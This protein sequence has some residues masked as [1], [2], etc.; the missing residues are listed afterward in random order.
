MDRDTGKA[1]DTLEKGAESLGHAR[2]Y[3]A[4]TKRMKLCGCFAACCP[5]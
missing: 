4:D 3:D 2:D 1:Q 5:K